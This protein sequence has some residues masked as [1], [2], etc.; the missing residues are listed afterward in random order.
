MLLENKKGS[1][2]ILAIWTTFFLSTLSIILGYNIR[3]KLHLMR[4]I[5]KLNCSYYLHQIAVKKAIAEILRFKKSGCIFLSNKN[6]I[7]LFEENEVNFCD[8]PNIIHKT[9]IY[10]NLKHYYGVFDEERKININ[11]ASE[12]LLKRLFQVILGIDLVE[13]QELAASIIDWKDD[14]SFL[15]I[16]FGSAEDNYYKTLQ[17]SYEA[18]DKQFEVLDELLLVKGINIDYFE[19]IKKFVTIYGDGKININTAPKEILLAIGL[20]EN[21]VNK[22][23]EFRNGKDGL[24]GTSDDNIFSTYNEIIPI[25]KN[26]ALFT[27]EE[28]LHLTVAAEQYFK[29]NSEFFIV[30]SY[31]FEQDKIISAAYFIINLDGKILYQR[32]V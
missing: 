5:E 4:H 21:I 17:F 19:K 1:V 8:V 14:D 26:S 12:S 7:N 2:L 31:V 15:S 11:I 25:L 9:Q 13:A 20:S 28:L 32:Q 27:E 6:D 23:I 22:L 18:K 3:T 10:N 24:E 16:P 30:K 29:V